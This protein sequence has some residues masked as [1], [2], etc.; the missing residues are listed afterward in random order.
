MSRVFF[1][2]DCAW[3][4]IPTTNANT[5]VTHVGLRSSMNGKP[6]AAIIPGPF[7]PGV[8]TYD[9]PGAPGLEERVLAWLAACFG[10][11]LYSLR[12]ARRAK[13]YGLP[14]YGGEDGY[15]RGGGKA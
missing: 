1:A 9:Q 6:P 8:A 2:K 13:R 3:R 10:R 11:R 7:K 12:A 5:L 14:Y 4:E 15:I